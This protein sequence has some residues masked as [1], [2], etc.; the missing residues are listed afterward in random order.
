MCFVPSLSREKKIK[1]K[2]KNNWM[3]RRKGNLGNRELGHCRYCQ[4]LLSVIFHRNISELRPRGAKENIFTQSEVD[5]CHETVTWAT[6]WKTQRFPATASRPK[7]RVEFVSGT[8]LHCLY[9]KDS[10]L[11]G[12]Q[13]F[14][15]GGR[16][17]QADFVPFHLSVRTHAC[18]NL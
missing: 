17:A 5:P 4:G 14:Q 6:N 3:K 15:D 13:H 9:R 16:D 12:V 11:P 2:E 1:E 8:D 7:S 10:V 18:H